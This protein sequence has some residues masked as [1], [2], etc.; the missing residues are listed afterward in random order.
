MYLVVAF[1]NIHSLYQAE[2]PGKLV[3]VREILLPRLNFRAESCEIE[4]FESKRGLRTQVVLPR[5]NKGST[6]IRMRRIPRC[7][8]VSVTVT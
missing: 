4:S 1:G 7:L 2:K 6:G 5:V 8:R 3:I